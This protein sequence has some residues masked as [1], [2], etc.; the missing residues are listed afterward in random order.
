VD[1]VVQVSNSNLLFKILDRIHK[2]KKITNTPVTRVALN[3][4]RLHECQVAW[5]N[6]G[7]NYYTNMSSLLFKDIKPFLRKKNLKLYNSINWGRK[8]EEVLKDLLKEN[9]E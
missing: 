9:N 8:T 5:N 2:S 7:G 3:F 4:S 1:L 6:T